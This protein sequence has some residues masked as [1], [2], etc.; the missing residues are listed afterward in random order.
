M[1]NFRGDASDGPSLHPPGKQSSVCPDATMDQCNSDMQ[2][3]ACQDDSVVIYHWIS[4]RTT[5]ITMDSG[6]D[7]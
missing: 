6:D 5:G 1:A 3:R 2:E 7:V 4:G